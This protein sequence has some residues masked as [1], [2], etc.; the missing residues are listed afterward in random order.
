M[1]KTQRKRAWI[2]RRPQPT[3][4]CVEESVKISR[5]QPIIEEVKVEEVKVLQPLVNEIP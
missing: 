1:K 4:D 5:P 3:E 2:T